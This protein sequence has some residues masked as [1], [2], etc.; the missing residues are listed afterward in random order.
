M[1]FNITFGLVKLDIQVGSGKLIDGPHLWSSYRAMFKHTD[2]V[3][4]SYTKLISSPFP[5][6]YT[7]MNGKWIEL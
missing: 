5:Y 3:S 1:L 4:Y 7:F 6:Y 2:T